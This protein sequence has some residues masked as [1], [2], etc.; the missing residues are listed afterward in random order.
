MWKNDDKWETNWRTSRVATYTTGGKMLAWKVQI[1]LGW[2]VWFH[3]LEL[4]PFPHLWLEMFLEMQGRSIQQA[5]ERRHDKN[6]W[7]HSFIL[8][9][10]GTWAKRRPY[11]SKGNSYASKWMNNAYWLYRRMSRSMR[12]TYLSKLTWLPFQPVTST[13]DDAAPT[14][15][16][17]TGWDPY[18]MM[19][20][21]AGKESFDREHRKRLR[22][23]HPSDISY[24][25]CDKKSPG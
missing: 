23:V 10:P 4:G 16:T 14:D 25:A 3:D 15:E 20:L 22:L 11:T 5:Y 7:H 8:Y 13:R 19:E 2:S 17:E 24:C 18:G 6:A 12:R 1:C 9:V 21:K